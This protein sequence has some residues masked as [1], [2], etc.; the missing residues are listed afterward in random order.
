MPNETNKKQNKD[1]QSKDKKHF[2]K[3]FKAELTKYKGKDIEINSKV[4]A[5]EIINELNKRHNDMFIYFKNKIIEHIK[6][7]EVPFKQNIH[8]VGEGFIVKDLHIEEII[9]NRYCVYDFKNKILSLSESEYNELKDILE[10]YW[11]N[12]GQNWMSRGLY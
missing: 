5:D 1:K 7:K 6:N 10:P 3:D 12:S 8:S 2:M 4:E 11:L 9:G